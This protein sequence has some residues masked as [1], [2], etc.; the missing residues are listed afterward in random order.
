[1]ENLIIRS[2]TTKWEDRD[3]TTYILEKGMEGV[4]GCIVNYYGDKKRLKE[5]IK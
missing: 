1:M 5:I 2:F 4:A 3:Y